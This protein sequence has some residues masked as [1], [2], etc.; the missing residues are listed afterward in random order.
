M[1]DQDRFEL[2]GT[3]LVCVGSE[4][5]RHDEP[6]QTSRNRSSLQVHSWRERYHTNSSAGPGNVR[7]M[8]F[9]AGRRPLHALCRLWAFSSNWSRERAPMTNSAIRGS[10]AATSSSLRFIQATLYESSRRET[11]DFEDTLSLSMR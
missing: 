1:E 4:S 6:N 7:P 2:C 5:H 8:A 10:L 11:K 9:T 3:K